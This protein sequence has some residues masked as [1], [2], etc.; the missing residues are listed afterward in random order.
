M[1]DYVLLAQMTLWHIILA[2]LC[3]IGSKVA[4]FIGEN[5]GKRL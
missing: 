1:M 5:R 4:V 2:S 3:A